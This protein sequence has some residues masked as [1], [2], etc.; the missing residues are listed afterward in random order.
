[1]FKANCL[2]L[3]SLILCGLFSGCAYIS[4]KT[5]PAFPVVE[6]PAPPGTVKTA[7]GLLL[8]KEGVELLGHECAGAYSSKNSD[9]VKDQNKRLMGYKITAICSSN[10]ET[11]TYNYSKIAYSSLGQ[12]A[13]YS[14]EIGCSRTGESHK[15]A[16]SN[17]T[18][19]NYWEVLT[20]QA[21]VDGKDYTYTRPQ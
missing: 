14:L 11:H 15:V 12:R 6:I 5:Q 2:A 9:M 4:G 16:V 18:Y 3:C 8:T 1:M 21:E 17:I 19:D 20:Y 13:G 10:S 7:S